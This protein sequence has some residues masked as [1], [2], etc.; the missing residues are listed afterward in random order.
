MEDYSPML[1]KI[2]RLVN[3]KKNNHYFH[4]SNDFSWI[5]DI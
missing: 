5:A 2:D 4:G 3:L 1:S